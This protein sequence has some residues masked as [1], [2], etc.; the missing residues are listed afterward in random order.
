MEHITELVADY[1]DNK[2][3]DEQNNTITTHLNECT[4]CQHEFEQLQALFAAFKAEEV[5]LPSSDLEQNFMK[6]LEEEQQINT[7]QKEQTNFSL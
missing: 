2:L 5:T 7:K 6:V 4:E 1:I 3:T